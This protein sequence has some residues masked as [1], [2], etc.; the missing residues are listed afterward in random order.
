[1]NDKTKLKLLKTNDTSLKEKHDVKQKSIL[2]NTE[3]YFG[4]NISNEKYLRDFYQLYRF[5]EELFQNFKNNKLLILFR[6]IDDLIMGLIQFNYEKEIVK[7]EGIPIKDILKSNKEFVEKMKIEIEKYKNN[8][9]KSYIDGVYFS[10]IEQV[11]IQNSSNSIEACVYRH[12]IVDRI[13]NA[14]TKFNNVLFKILSQKELFLGTKSPSKG[15]TKNINSLLAKIYYEIISNDNLNKEF[16][17]VLDNNKDINSC[18][19]PIKIV[20]NK[21]DKEKLIV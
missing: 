13:K 10:E 17:D 8:P 1:M 2:I 21:L 9:H 6:S 16:I 4:S 14:N 12:E 19:Y 11:I 3:E 15:K 7:N 5:Y 20:F 18:S